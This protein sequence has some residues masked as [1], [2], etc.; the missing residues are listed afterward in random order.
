MPSKCTY[1]YEM[2][3][4]SDGEYLQQTICF[5]C[6]IEIVIKPKESFSVGFELISHCS[7]C[8]DS[9]KKKVET[10]NDKKKGEQ[11]ATYKYL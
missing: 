5:W 7:F 3:V 9:T 10:E 2:R 4:E 6:G 1:A 8:E 11:C